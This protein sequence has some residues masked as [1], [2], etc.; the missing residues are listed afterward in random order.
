MKEALSSS[1][2]S[3]LTGAT[4]RNIPEDTIL[5]SHRRKNFESYNRDKCSSDMLVSQ[6]TPWDISE[7][8]TSRTY[9]FEIF[10]TNWTLM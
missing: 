2:P 7:D 10:K 9:N 8:I 3:V 5:H 1:E 4:R 6:Q